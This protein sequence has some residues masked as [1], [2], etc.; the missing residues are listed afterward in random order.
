MERFSKSRVA[1]KWRGTGLYLFKAHRLLY[2]ST[3]GSSVIKKNKVAFGSSS[4]RAEWMC[5]GQR[6]CVR[7]RE[8]KSARERVPERERV[9][10]G[11]GYYLVA[12]LGD[13]EPHHPR[14]Q[15]CRAVCG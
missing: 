1:S 14:Q 2:H 6:V 13:L 4:L 7:A 15:P 10:G 5:V 3:L 12:V 8:R 11:V 9:D